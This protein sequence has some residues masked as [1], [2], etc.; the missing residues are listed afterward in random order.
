MRYKVGDKVRVREDL[1]VAKMYGNLTLY[2][3]LMEDLK[4]QILTV[5]Y[6]G[7]NYSFEETPFHLSEEMIEGLVTNTVDEALVASSENIYTKEIHSETAVAFNIIHERI[8]NKLL[9]K[10][11]EKQMKEFFIKNYKVCDNNGV[12]TLVVDFE[13]GSKER[14]VCCPEDPF[15]LQRGLEIVVLKHILGRDNYKAMIK[16][17]M[18]QIKAIDKAAEEAK[19]EKEMIA[20]KK[21][22]A[23]RKK[24]RYKANKRKQR[25][26]EMKEAYVA[27]MK[28][29]GHVDISLDDLK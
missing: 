2:S 10:K 23:A 15:E 20:A 11:E 18:K 26:A 4:G 7:S 28:E 21:A 1:V 3:G 19:K 9:D 8:K 24:A 14:A 6:V 13:D 12:K 27:A 17:A 29:C 16:T 5:K 22:S 25:I